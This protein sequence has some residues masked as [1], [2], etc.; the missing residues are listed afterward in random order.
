[1]QNPQKKRLLQQALGAQIALLRQRAG[2]PKQADLYRASGVGVRT[3]SDIET[4]KTVP[5]IGTMRKI[6]AA[7][8]LP[9]GAT[10]DFLAGKI[11]VLQPT[12]MAEAEAHTPVYNADGS[13]A[14]L[15]EVEE[16]MW[17]VRGASRADRWEAIF[18]RRDRMAQERIRMA[19]ERQ[20]RQ[21]PPLGQTGG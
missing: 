14:G 7:L 11:K 4:G 2:M 3:I 19:R 13:P 15:D 16:A 8:H 20:S 18:E 21:E 12:N 17:L 10:D 5:R 9:P 1:M 6:E